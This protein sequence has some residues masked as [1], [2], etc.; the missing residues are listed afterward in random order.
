MSH[1]KIQALGSP[2]ELKRKFA[3]GFRMTAFLKDSQSADAAIQ[4]FS[5]QLE[6][7]EVIKR[8][9]KAIFFK[10][11]LVDDDPKLI[12]FFSALEFKKKALGIDDFSVGLATME[13]VFLELSKRDLMDSSDFVTLQYQV[14]EGAEP[15]MQIE[16]PLPDGGGSHTIV[17]GEEPVPG[18]NMTVRVPKTKINVGDQTTAEEDFGKGTKTFK[19][20]CVAL[21]IKTR[22]LQCRKKCELAALIL[23]PI[24]MVAIIALIDVLLFD[25]FRYPPMCGKGIYNKE[26]CQ[27]KGY[28]LSCIEQLLVLPRP[29]SASQ[30]WYGTPWYTWFSDMNCG[31]DTGGTYAEDGK[32][33]LTNGTECYNHLEK[34]TW[35]NLRYSAPHSLDAEVGVVSYQTTPELKSWHDN[36]EYALTSKYC[37]RTVDW[38]FDC[39]SVCNY[40]GD[41][42]DDDDV[43]REGSGQ[44][45]DD[46]AERLRLSFDYGFDSDPEICQEQCSNLTLTRSVGD[47]EINDEIFGTCKP[48]LKDS[49]FEGWRRLQV[50]NNVNDPEV[51][52]LTADNSNSFVTGSSRRR[53]ANANQW[54]PLNSSKELMEKI[55]QVGG[56]CYSDWV[57]QVSRWFVTNDANDPAATT[58][59]FNFINSVDDVVKTEVRKGF[60]G[61]FTSSFVEDRSF[62]EYMY[63]LMDD[64]G[65]DKISIND[66][67]DQVNPLL[68]LLSGMKKWQS[69]C[70]TALSDHFY[71]QVSYQT[72]PNVDWSFPIV[73]VFYIP[74]SVIDAAI[75]AST[76]QAC[77]SW[78][79]R[80]VKDQSSPLTTSVCN[81]KFK[82]ETDMLPIEDA[83]DRTLANNTGITTSSPLKIRQIC[84]YVQNIDAIRNLTMVQSNSLEKDM[85]ETN[86]RQDM[87]REIFTNYMQSLDVYHVGYKR[88]FYEADIAAF[89]FQEL[90]LKT[91]VN[92]YS[93]YW[94]LSGSGSDPFPLTQPD[95][96]HWN[97]LLKM[98]NNM[99]VQNLTGGSHF[100]GTVKTQQFP[101][102]FECNRDEF[103]NDKTGT[104]KLSC[105]SLGVDGFLTNL[106][107]YF[108]G[109]LMLWFYW[110]PFYSAV[111]VPVYEKEHRLR[112]IMRMMGLT[113]SVYWITMYILEVF[114]FLLIQTCL[115]IFCIALDISYFKIHDL[116]L[117]YLFVTVWAMVC[118]MFA[119]LV[120]MCLESTKTASAVAFL[121]FL[122]LV[123][124][125]QELIVFSTINGY[126]IEVVILFSSIF[127]FE[128]VFNATFLCFLSFRT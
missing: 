68:G 121:I 23:F 36:F 101:N 44:S 85:Y 46:P 94:N 110:L 74:P 123:F 22:Q 49:K 128:T 16:M 95:V 107:G 108:V 51:E 37:D 65:D 104:I 2:L 26:D 58:G 59:S 52:D 35:D 103:L 39:E 45:T 113:S 3:V 112:M 47:G 12:P 78:A 92:N 17:L 79:R 15:G 122:L 62:S 28:N 21:T 119:F 88:H 14:P 50:K 70:S 81:K 127:F 57:E 98:A 71:V 6:G 10:V 66:I 100:I 72:S 99:F 61:H 120:S 18:S 53:L 56:E 67:V 124:C 77:P 91:G 29:P 86:K 25:T 87:S 40:G 80:E 33:S 43:V 126:V 63:L 11:P 7:I 116:S 24:S 20:T 5:E 30:V 76:G 89:N 109:A 118:T 54:K 41:G 69:L 48:D 82:R 9:E 19:S 106:V 34:L 97:H 55:N 111:Q 64:K 42:D 13:E 102:E 125:G 73:E 93:V 31:S 32:T 1:G 8:L 105:P 84:K 114:K 75:L 60:L 83:I 27:A 38:L 90:S 4:F 117:I 96:G 115:Y